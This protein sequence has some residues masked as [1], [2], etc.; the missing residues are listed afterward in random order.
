ML[1]RLSADPTQIQELIRGQSRG[2]VE[3]VA[4]EARR[5]AAS[6][7]DVVDRLVGRVLHRRPRSID[8]PAPVAPPL[9]LTPG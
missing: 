5:R 6:G 2:M 7:D 4:R 9:N 1:D 3:G 8:G